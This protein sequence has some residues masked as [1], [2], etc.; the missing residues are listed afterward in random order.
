MPEAPKIAEITAKPLIDST[1]WAIVPSV[2]W[3]LIVAFLILRFQTEFQQ[4]FKALASRLRSGAALKVAGLE[5]GEDS[6]LN[7]KPG[8]FSGED[9]RIGVR[10]DDGARKK[11]RD[12]LYAKSRGV[13]LAHRLQRSSQ[14]G[15]LYDILIYVIPHKSVSLVGV[16]TVEYFFGHYWGNKIFPSHDRSRGF[17]VVTS[18]YGPFLCTAKVIYNDG[19]EIVISRY[20]DFEMGGCA[21][22]HV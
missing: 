17:P 11:Q 7:A 14:D 18:G 16:C 1:F 21:P 19:A 2:L 22:T 6:G 12:A 9:S 15:Q 8:D 13:M 20:I 5:I 4:I 3:T 10:E